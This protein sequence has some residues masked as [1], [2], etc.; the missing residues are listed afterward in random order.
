MKLAVICDT[1]AGIKN[2][3]QVFIDYQNK[4]Y[5]DTFFPYLAKHKI[6]KIL[7]L[8]DFFDNRRYLN[9]K[10]INSIRTGFLE[11]LV[12]YNL[13]MD[14]IPGNHDVAFKNTNDIC[15]LSEILQQYSTNITVHMVPTVVSYDS[16]RI[17]LLP[18]INSENY[19]DS[20]KFVETADAPFLAA[21]LELS[22]FEMMKGA[23]ATS[24]GMDS[25]LFN[26]Y[27]AVLSGHYHTKSTKGNI[28][29][30]G[31]P[32][33]HTWAD[34]NDPKYFHVIDTDTREIIPVRN[35]VCIFKKLVYDDTLFENPVEALNTVD[36]NHLNGTFVKVV[37][38]GK[39]DPFAFDKYCDK[40]LLAEPFDLKIVESFSEYS[41]EEVADEL[42]NIADTN[43]LLNSYVDAVETELSKDKLKSK[44]QELY[45]EA[46]Q[47]DAL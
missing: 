32:F 12:E 19:A 16:L 30:L 38:A 10:T 18:W 37:V 11:K 2:G 28:H 44:L 40:I 43:T 17:G 7:H 14:I 1:H 13:H 45:A 8:G 9:V 5:A 4:F 31:V 41:S 29:Y 25:V 24:H 23:P 46:Q 27:E 33:E 39:K 26:R 34:C 47:L 42:V 6:S 3:S 35:S 21:H 22:G 20:I 15:S 36:F